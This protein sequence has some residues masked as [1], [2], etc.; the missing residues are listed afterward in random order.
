M[1]RIAKTENSERTEHMTTIRI[2]PEKVLRPIKQLNGVGGGPQTSRFSVDAT[3][4]FIEAGIPYCRTHDI[5]YPLGLGEFVDVHC[6][7]KDFDRDENDPAAYNFTM[8]DLY[9]QAIKDAGA[10]P[11][12]RLGTSI[13]HQPVKLHIKPPK[14]FAK[15]ARICSHIVSHYNEGWADG[16]HMGIRYWEIM[17]EPD[18]PPCWTGTP[19][20]IIELYCVAAKILKSEHPDILVG[21]PAWADSRRDTP[22]KLLDRIV[23]ENVPLDFFSWH[24]YEKDPHV[25]EQWMVEIDDILAKRGLTHVEIILDE[26]NYVVSWVKGMDRAWA[27]IATPFECAFMSAVMCAMQK[28]NVNKMMYYDVQNGTVW[29]GAFGGPVSSGVHG[30]GGHRPRRRPGYYALKAWN[31]LKKLGTQVDASC[32]L[33]NVY[34]TAAK[35]EKDQIA[36]LL[37]YFEDSAGYNDEKPEDREFQIECPGDRQWIAFVVDDFHTYTPVQ[38]PE[39]K[40]TLPG[41]ASALICTTDAIP[42]I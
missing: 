2:D 29:N 18:I 10:E 34:L 40:L 31:T 17:N 14:D 1:I 4:D 19:E 8:T 6:I 25:Y 20:Q 38:M 28:T 3:K 24:L 21:G 35:G 32:E 26:W 42:F 23:A 12:V 36:M 13:E 11:F 22:Q 41:N 37:S 27:L 7:F 39:G 9:F 33:N 16:F 5:E 15:W 30:S